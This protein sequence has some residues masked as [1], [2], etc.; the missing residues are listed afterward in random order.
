MIN[1]QRRAGNKS[2]RK[3]KVREIESG[4]EGKA[5]RNNFQDSRHVQMRS[6][7][8]LVDKILI[9]YNETQL[10]LIERRSVRSYF[11]A[12]YTLAP[13]DG[14]AIGIHSVMP[15]SWLH[16]ATVIFA[17]KFGRSVTPPRGIVIGRNFASRI[18]CVSA[19]MSSAVY[20]MSCN[21]GRNSHV[22]PTTGFAIASDNS[23]EIGDAQWKAVSLRNC[24]F[25][26]ETMQRRRSWRG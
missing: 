10:L 25:R 15:H 5:G 8:S 9:K 2:H 1:R 14:T 22:R 6:L 17:C 11:I 20:P 21:V 13:R 23:S 19:G 12:S 3:A 26:H 24:K 4:K 7:W 18:N 16:G